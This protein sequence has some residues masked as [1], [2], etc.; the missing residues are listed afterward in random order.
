[1]DATAALTPVVLIHGIRV[2]STMWRGQQEALA[3][4][5]RAATAVDL[6]GHGVRSAE[7]FTIDGAMAVVRGAVEDLGGT[8]VVAGLSLGGYIAISYAARFPD[9]VAGLVAADCS[10]EP[11]G[12]AA[13]SFEIVANV[14]GHL[15]DHG[16]RLNHLVLDRV[17]P[18]DGARDVAAGGFSP[19]VVADVVDALRGT[20][21]CADLASLQVPVWIVNGEWDHFRIQERKFVRSCADGRLVIIHGAGHLSNL[22]APVEFTRVLLEALDDIDSRRMVGAGQ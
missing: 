1:M 11:A 12:I 5:G 14:I 13:L 19:L 16:E 21:P 6:P 18:D 4:T 3:A 8:A 20:D 17:L 7:P 22:M 15:P 10:A 2:T 9:T